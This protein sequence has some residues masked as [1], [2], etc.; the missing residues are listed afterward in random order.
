MT[1][2]RQVLSVAAVASM[3][4]LIAA[5]FCSLLLFAG[6]L[7]WSAPGGYQSDLSVAFALLIPAYVMLTGLPVVLIVAPV[8]AALLQFGLAKWYFVA[9]LAIG[10][11][12][13]I[14]W[15]TPPLG[16]VAVAAG[17]FVGAMT[18]FTMMRRERQAAPI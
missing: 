7:I 18:H 5:A 13:L 15:W 4:L 10:P 1:Y 9:P 17:A 3:T 11:G 14:W 16:P 8:Y 6:Q 2:I 12:A